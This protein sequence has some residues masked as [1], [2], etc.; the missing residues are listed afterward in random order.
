MVPAYPQISPAAHR[1]LIVL[2]D[3]APVH[4]AITARGLE[5]RR[6][7]GGLVAAV[8]PVISERSGTWL[9][10]GSAD[11]VA[12]AGPCGELRIDTPGLPYTLRYIQLDDTLSRGYYDG[13]AHEGLWPL[14][15]DVGVAPVFRPDDFVSYQRVNEIFT[16][17]VIERYRA[18]AAAIFV[19]GYHFALAPGLIRRRE[20]LAPITLF[21]HIPWPAAATLR[22]CPWAVPLV[23]GLLG[24]DVIGFQTDEDVMRFLDGARCVPGA[25]VD[26]ARRIVVTDGRRVSVR[27]SAAAGAWASRDVGSEVV[28]ACRARVLSD[29]GLSPRVRIGLGID[30]L[31][32][33]KGLPEKIAALT[34]L[35]E[36]CPEWR[37]QFTFVQVVAP[38]R[39]QIAANRAARGRLLEAVA[40]LNG[41]LETADWTPVVLLDRR[42]SADEL[43]RFY[44]AADL[45]YINSL[46]DGMNL[47]AK[48]YVTARSDEA[49]VL[50][51]SARAGASEQLRAAL[52]VDPQNRLQCADSLAAA[53]A[54]SPGEQKRRMRALRSAVRQTDS[55]WWAA[56]MLQNGRP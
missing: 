3:R 35:F 31:D 39:E 56:E 17:A 16:D 9:A 45:C 11:D 6:G 27:A 1:R 44:R 34:T 46:A 47:V 53:L 52:M 49:G 54:M 10:R 32:Y 20:P 29:L 51:L 23:D 42:A 21:W 40:R 13:F 55:G 8:E 24:A 43:E 33:T 4:H 30:R 14:C 28:P 50:V 2:A 26:H 18:S 7:A 38:S 25:V 37:G 36:R 15:H 19:N 22:A 12:A 41:N 5:R 48:A